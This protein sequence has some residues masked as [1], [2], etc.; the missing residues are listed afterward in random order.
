MDAH[1]GE[2]NLH[3]SDV[4]GASCL[5]IEREPSDE[6]GLRIPRQIICPSITTTQEDKK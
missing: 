2:A 3:V 1:E 5:E 4:E 6:G